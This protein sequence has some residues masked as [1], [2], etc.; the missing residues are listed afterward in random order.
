M[1]MPRQ[2]YVYTL[3][4]KQTNKQKKRHWVERICFM[5]THGTWLQ[6]IWI[7]SNVLG[8]IGNKAHQLNFFKSPSN[9]TFFLF[10]IQLHYIYLHAQPHFSYQI[11]KFPPHYYF[12]TSSDD[13]GCIKYKFNH[14]SLFKTLTIPSNIEIYK[15]TIFSCHTS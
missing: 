15:H 1:H 4:T 2:R 7:L 10:T 8:H 6:I 13:S 9:L 3:Y 5:D 14:Y 12:Q 11:M